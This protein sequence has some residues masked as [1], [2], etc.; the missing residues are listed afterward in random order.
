MGALTKTVLE[1]TAGWQPKIVY[2]IVVG[3]ALIPV[4]TPVL[5]ST[6]AIEGSAEDHSPPPKVEV[7]VVVPPM[8]MEEGP[9]TI[10]ADGV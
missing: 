1:E 6:V 3:P 2:R 7:K 8:Q 5:G 9:F 10:P 4:I